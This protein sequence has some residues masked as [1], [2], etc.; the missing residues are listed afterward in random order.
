V[1]NSDNSLFIGKEH[2]S[3]DGREIKHMSLI[4]TFGTF[5]Q[6]KVQDDP[7]QFIGMDLETDHITGE[8]KLLGFWEDGKYK[9]YMDHF[10]SILY[11]Y[12]RKSIYENKKIVWWNRLDPY[13]LFKQFLLP[14]EKSTTIDRAMQYFGKIGGEYD[15][16]GNNWIVKPVISVMIGDHEFGILHAIRSSIQFYIKDGDEVKKTWAYDIASM[17]LS[18]LEKEATS[19][20][21]WYSKVDKSAHLVDWVRFDIDGNYADNIV[22][23][24]NMLD[25][26]AVHDLA[27]E[28]LNQFHKAF[29]KYP[30][31]LISQG[32]LA[33]SALVAQMENMGLDAKEHGKRIGLKHHMD[34]IVEQL[35]PKNAKDFF[36]LVT[37]AYSAGYIEAIR[38][39]TA[40]HGAYADIASAYPAIIINLY[41]LEGATYTYGKGTP[42]RAK[43]GYTFIRGR[44]EVPKDN[45]F[46]PITIKHPVH[47]STNI[48]ASGNYIASYTIEER[49]FMLSQGAKFTEETYVKIE[50][51]GELSPLAKVALDF[52]ELRSKLIA[53][54]D[55]AQYMAKIASNSLYGILFECVNTY[56]EETVKR[57]I[58][59]EVKDTFY[60]DILKHYRKKIDFTGI[61]S[62]LKMYFDTDYNKIRAMWHGKSGISPDVVKQEIELQGIYLD[63][64]HPADILYDINLLYRKDKSMKTTREYNEEVVYKAGYRAG[65]FFNP[66]FATYITA[67]TRIKLASASVAIEDNGGKVIALMT[68]SITW[69]GNP[70]MLPESFWKEEKTLGYFEKPEVVTDI[71]SLGAGRYGFRSKDG[72]QITKRRGIDAVESFNWHELLNKATCNTVTMTT[73][74]LISVGMVLGNHDYTFKDLGR[75]VES[76]REVDL[77]VGLTKR[78]LKGRLNLK[79]L[80]TKLVDTETFIIPKY[81]LGDN[82]M[83]LPNLR[84]EMFKRPYRLKKEKKKEYSRRT[85]IIHYRANK[86]QINAKRRKLYNDKKMGHS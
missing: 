78:P 28:T 68:D 20:F 48:R 60:Q 25:A 42:P 4:K 76:D 81:M 18:G 75:I 17:Y 11:N 12:V 9:Y 6:N 38:Y 82:D 10:L 65:E 79:E 35:G 37:E 31:S 85:S 61:E 15:R 7:M 51:T 34:S 72:Y 19:R 26:R 55:S 3:M 58:R 23:K 62:E 21:D 50:T 64:D 32:S 27:H 67:M 41:D 83:A 36:A 39:G 77:V 16:K 40:E 2:L 84:L 46:N 33:R 44:I 53:E 47:K 80:K 45:V 57:E 52:I 1:P 69:E 63:S 54:N 29:K 59:E 43:H 8:L 73:R 13:I 30:K 49:D 14:Q 74:A 70:N 56:E 86:E 71:I 24:S 22:L 5:T 66:I